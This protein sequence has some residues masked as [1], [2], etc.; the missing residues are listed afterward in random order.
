M[1]GE[2]KRRAL[3]VRPRPGELVARYGRLKDE[4][5][6]DLVLHWGGE[7]A[8]KADGGFLSMVLSGVT[9]YDANAYGRPEAGWV[10]R[11]F[12]RRGYDL[13][14]LRFSIRRAARE[15]AR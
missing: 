4:R 2:K 14:T 12:E 11:E 5:S 1:S 3:V 10:L 13:R 7:G 15:V 6:D 9:V 8:T